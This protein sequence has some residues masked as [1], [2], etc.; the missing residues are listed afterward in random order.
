MPGVFGK[1]SKPNYNSVV[2]TFC[3]NIA[4]NKT[5][6]ISDKNFEVSLIYIDDVI[7]IICNTIKKKQKD[8]HI[9]NCNKNIHKIKLGQLYGKIEKFNQARINLDPINIVRGFN[10]K[11]MQLCFLSS[12]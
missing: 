6:H 10:K 1:W 5:S 11:L 8:C 2:S 7:E 4:N 9:I 3:Y 12:F